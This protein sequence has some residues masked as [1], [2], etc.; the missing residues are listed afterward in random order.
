MKNSFFRNAA[1]VV[2][3]AAVALPGFAARGTANFSHFVVIGDSYGAGLEAGSL[4]EQ[5]Q[6]VSWP[7]VV[8]R[9][10][11]VTVFQQPLVSYPGIGPELKLR[12]AIG[13]PP[14]ITAEPGQGQPINLTLPVPYNNLSIPGATVED[15]ITLTGREN[16]PV[17]TAQQFAQFI[18][19]GLGTEVQQAIAQQPT[20]IAVWIGG[21]NAL[22]AVLNGSTNFLDTTAN[23]T[24]AYNK[25]LD[26]LIAGAPNAGMVVGN[27]PMH[28]AAAPFASTVPPVII[29]PATRTPV[30]VNGAPVSYIY[31]AG[32]GQIAQLPAGSFVT[33]GAS[34]LLAQG[35]GIPPA[36]KDIPPFNLLPKV[37]TPLPD[38][39]V[40]TPTEVTA[41]EARLVEFNAIINQAASARNIPVADISS[42][43]DRVQGRREFVG[44]FS[45]TSDFVTGGFF[46]LDGF[47]L[48]DIGYTLFADE[49]IKAINSGYGTKIPQASIANFLQN[50]GAFLGFGE[51]SDIGFSQEAID[52]IRSFAPLA[53]QP[54]R[55]RSVHH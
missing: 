32:N 21:N 50:N 39:V 37:G 40:L 17:G 28:V 2:L 54:P 1:A 29:N 22:G 23:F 5:H 44:P 52:Q 46:S 13:Y 15:V 36:F 41:I 10:A 25:M 3:T 38:A 20:F 47:H 49:F 27:L 42:L 48:T 11:G 55:F 19:R 53:K 43:F 9:Q 34:A 8:A 18:L 45:F 14:V 35:Y 51:A 12:D 31:D 16:P 24:A 26:D 4:N 30:I 6:V 7:A 33:L